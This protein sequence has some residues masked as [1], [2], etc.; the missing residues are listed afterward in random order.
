M[1][2]TCC[3]NESQHFQMK[4]DFIPANFHFNPEITNFTGI[5][6][7]SDIHYNL[8]IPA[9]NRIPAT[10]SPPPPELHTYLSRIQSYLL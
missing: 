1:D 8:Y 4:D 7:F 2:G 9:D 10:E 3:H 6:F 5:N